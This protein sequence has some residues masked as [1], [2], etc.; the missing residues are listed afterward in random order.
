[1]SCRSEEAVPSSW[2]RVAETML[3]EFGS[4]SSQHVL[5]SVSLPQPVSDTNCI[6]CRNAVCQIL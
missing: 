4:S 5:R 6:D 2:T 1:M 3:S